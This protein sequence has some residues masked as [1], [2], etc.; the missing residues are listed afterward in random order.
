MDHETIVTKYKRS[1]DYYFYT[2]NNSVVSS[3]EPVYSDEENNSAQYVGT[4]SSCSH[5]AN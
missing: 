5:R 1:K 2:C 4:P 3:R